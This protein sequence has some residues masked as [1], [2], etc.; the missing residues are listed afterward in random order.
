MTAEMKLNSGVEVLKKRANAPVS[1][2]LCSDS[3]CPCLPQVPPNCPVQLIG[4]IAPIERFDIEPVCGREGR[5]CRHR[6]G[7][8][9]R[10]SAGWATICCLQLGG[11][12][13]FALWVEYGNSFTRPIPSTRFPGRMEE[14]PNGRFH[15]II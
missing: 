9:V 3:Q 14:Y 12:A 7:G 6:G 13:S 5:R 1:V 2:K 8:C 15:E 10:R 4:Q 11:W